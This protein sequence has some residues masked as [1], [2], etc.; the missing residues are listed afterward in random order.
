MHKHALTCTHPR[1][2][3]HT[4]ATAHARAHEHT[5]L[6]THPTHTVQD[7]C[8]SF[9]DL[10][11][12]VRRHSSVSL[13]YDLLSTYLFSSLD[14]FFMLCFAQCG[15]LPYHSKRVYSDL[16][17]VS[18]KDPKF[19]NPCLNVYAA[20][21][22]QVDTRHWEKMPQTF[23][24]LVQH[25]MDHLD[26]VLMCDRKVEGSEPVRRQDFEADKA[27]YK[28]LVDYSIIP[29]TGEFIQ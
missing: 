6:L 10:L 29:T 14:S 12:K 19:T 23:A 26:G 2:R 15:S 1:A 7:D 13:K 25:E 8:M 9:P 20:A 27:K 5:Q 17:R 3:T 24:E 16:F 18:L 21:D 22:G 28:A 4:H 11:F